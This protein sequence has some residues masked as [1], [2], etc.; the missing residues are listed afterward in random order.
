M[1]ATDSQIEEL[2]KKWFPQIH[3]LKEEMVATDSQ[4]KRRKGSHRLTD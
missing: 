2:R 1:V 4:I 3:R